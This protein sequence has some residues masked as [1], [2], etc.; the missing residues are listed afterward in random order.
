MDGF[1][2]W[3]DCVPPILCCIMF[4]SNSE[5]C[6]ITLT[7]FPWSCPASSSWNF[8]IV[9]F[10]VTFSVFAEPSWPSPPET[11]NRNVRIV[12]FTDDSR[13]RSI[14]S[15]SMLT[16]DGSSSLSIVKRLYSCTTLSAV[17]VNSSAIVLHS[18]VDTAKSEY[19]LVSQSQSYIPLEI[20][21]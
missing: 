19:L 9:S 21:N 11:T 10:I 14:V 2:V 7:I 16:R 15:L 4:S 3:L 5:Y 18:C 6:C 13:P 12:S 8:A 1:Y 20:H 17:R